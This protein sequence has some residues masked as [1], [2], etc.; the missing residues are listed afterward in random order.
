[1]SGSAPSF[2]GTGLQTGRRRSKGNG[3]LCRFVAWL[4]QN[5]Q[6]LKSESDA[7]FRRPIIGLGDMQEYGAAEAGPD[8]IV[9]V[10]KLDDDVVNVVLTPKGFV[11]AR[12]RKRDQAII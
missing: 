12:K 10:T 11:A 6:I 5:Q 7:P 4:Q 9:V 2:S 3:E 1:M 8:R